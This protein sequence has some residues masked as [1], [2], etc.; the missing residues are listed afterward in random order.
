M[1]KVVLSE[2]SLIHGEV[3]TPKGF[4][5]DLKEI[6]NSI[7][8]S[9]V[10]GNRVSKNKKDYSYNDYNVEFSLPLQW[11]KDYIRDHF[12]AEH[13]HSLI[14]VLNFGN[15][16]EPKEKSLNRNNVDPVDLRNAADYTCV[17]GVDINGDCDLVIEY[18]DNRR[19]GRT[20]HIPIKNNN[21]YIFPSTQRYFF[22][23]NKSN[24]LNTILTMTYNYS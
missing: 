4:E 11:L 10:N 8:N 23:E 9:F 2:I 12:K 6:K 13:Y 3:K 24:K 16:L 20:W 18:A 14:P 19:A 1:Q 15:V 17:F 7:I 5:I 22:T 21:Y